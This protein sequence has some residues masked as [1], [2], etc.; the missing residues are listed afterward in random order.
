MRLLVALALT[1]AATT[2]LTEEENAEC[3][4]LDASGMPQYDLRPLEHPGGGYQVDG[5]DSGYTFLLNVCSALPKAD[6]GVVAQWQHS[7]HNG[8]LGRLGA[9]P[10]LR[11]DSLIL[12]YVGGDRCPETPALRKS[13][14]MLFTCDRD[15]DGY[16]HPEFVAQW[17]HCAFTFQWRTPAACPRE[18]SLDEGHGPES[19]RSNSSGDDGAPGTSRGAV[20]FVAVFVLGSIYIL[21]GFLY[22]RVLNMSSG[23]RGLEQL[24]NYRFWRAIYRGGRWAVV[25]AVDGVTYI[26]EAVNGRRGAIRIDDAEYSIRNE[27][28]DPVDGEQEIAP[29]SL[30]R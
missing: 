18:Q 17:A 30:R 13:L 1:A 20:V 19:G 29:I 22:N 27:L 10:Q 24:P 7:G 5:Y 12:E 6:E 3:I 9:V 16:G 2:A 15:A 4:V 14:L 11:G 25:S 8:S 28:F 26:A 23:L 21:G